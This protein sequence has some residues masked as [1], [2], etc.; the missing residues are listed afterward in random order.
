M[1]PGIDATPDGSECFHLKVQAHDV[2]VE[3]LGVAA[4]LIYAVVGLAIHLS[5]V[6]TDRLRRGFF[7]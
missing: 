4:A 7:P 2:V 3:I 6:S 5:P 1:L